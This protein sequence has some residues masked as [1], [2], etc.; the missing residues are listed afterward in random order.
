MTSSRAPAP[1]PAPAPPSREALARSA[2][3]ALVGSTVVTLGLYLTPSLYPIA[4]PL[5]LLST[6]V[7]ELGHG[8]GSLLSGGGWSE[9]RMFSD[10]SGVAHILP[11]SDFSAAFACAAGLVGPALIAA[12]YLAAGLRPRLARAALAATGA[13]FA[14]ALLL[15][16]RG[17]F[18]MAFVAA[19]AAGCLAVAA[20]TSPATAR[21]VLVFLAT[22]LAL[23]VFSRGDYL[24]TDYVA[25]QMSD[26]SR[27]PADVKIMEMAIGM[28]YWFWGLACGAF[29]VAVLVLAGWLYVRPPR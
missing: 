20:L 7:H 3:W 16:V 29:S 18:G 5:M 9:F 17:G 22:Q 14:L 23:S 21:L 15:W 10:G 25:G 24:F 13:F 19:L 2:R 26:G 4:Y 8:V 27:T 1:A 12:L 6:L 11:A 28:P